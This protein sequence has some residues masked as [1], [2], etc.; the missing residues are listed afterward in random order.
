M[1]E[2]IKINNIEF[3]FPS[4][5][6]LTNFQTTFSRNEERVQKGTIILN[7]INNKVLLKSESD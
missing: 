6:I 1:E 4:D 7:P 2:S 3:P 5:E